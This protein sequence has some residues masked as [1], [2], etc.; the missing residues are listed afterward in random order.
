MLT[1]KT[2]VKFVNGVQ[3]FVVLPV[4]TTIAANRHDTT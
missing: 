2:F 1:V 4:F 3:R